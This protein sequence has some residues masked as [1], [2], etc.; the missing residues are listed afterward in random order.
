[1]VLG[2][3]LALGAVLFERHRPK[4]S[5]LSEEAKR[6]SKKVAAVAGF[7]FAGAIMI[8]VLWKMNQ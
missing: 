5:D 1:M 6:Y 4:D 2:G 3:I 7:G 8:F